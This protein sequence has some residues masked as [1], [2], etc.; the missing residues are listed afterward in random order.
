MKQPIN[1]DLSEIVTPKK[2]IERAVSQIDFTPQS[3]MFD[4]SHEESKDLI[5]Q[6][7]EEV[8]EEVQEEEKI[9]DIP[10]L[11]PEESDN[12]LERGSSD[13]DFTYEIKK[14]TND[15]LLNVEV[16]LNHSRRKE[17]FGQ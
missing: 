1:V 14:A 5:D 13:L 12:T 17:S 7:P 6:S 10:V 8:Q 11:K 2:E 16:Q 4:E 9:P 15:T 3:D